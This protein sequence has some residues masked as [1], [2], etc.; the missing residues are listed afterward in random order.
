MQTT[1][2]TEI[3]YLIGSFPGKDDAS[4]RFDALTSPKI[5]ALG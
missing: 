2:L 1:R 4:V 3:P 5:L